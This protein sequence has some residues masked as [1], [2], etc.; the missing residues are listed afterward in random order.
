MEVHA[1]DDKSPQL[2]QVLE[3]HRRFRATLGFLPT[4]AFEERAAVGTLLLAVDGAGRAIGYALYDLPRAEIALRHLCVDEPAR[5]KGAAKALVEAIAERHPERRGIRVRCR[6]DWPANGMWP[7]LDF[8][9]VSDAPGRSVAGHLLTTWWRDFG[10]PTLFTAQESVGP[11]VRLAIDTDVFIDLSTDRPGCDESRG[12]LSDWVVE[13][14]EIVV[15]KEVTQ[16]LN[17]HS[18]PATRDQH[19]ARLQGFQRADASPAEWARSVDAL[20]SALPNAS[21][22]S[23]HDEADIRHVARAHAA[24]VRYFVTRDEGLIVR[25]AEPAAMALGMVVVSPGAFL[26]LLWDQGADTYAPARIENTPIAVDAL[27]GNDIDLVAR[28]FLNH[29]SG[30]RLPAFRQA[31]RRLLADPQRYETR[32]VRV[33][34]GDVLGVFSRFR[35]GD[36]LEVPLL[37]TAGRLSGTIGR[38]IVYLQRLHAR[39]AGTPLVRVSEKELSASVVDALQAE[40]FVA[41]TS[42]WW[43][44]VVSTAGSARDIA[45]ELLTVDG[46]PELGLAH[47]AEALRGLAAPATVIEIESRF[48]PL[49]VRNA[50]VPTY[51]V[52]IRAPFAQQLFD[53]DLST[54]TLFARS[55]SLGL[56]REHVYYRARRPNVMQAP[57]RIV[58]YVSQDPHLP[59][60]GAIRA[61]SRLVEI[62]IE[63]PRTLYRRFGHLGVYRL[64]DV[65]Q[66]AGSSGVAMAVRFTDTETLRPVSLSVLREI[67]AR[68]GRN[69]SLRSPWKLPEGMFDEIY[70]RGMHE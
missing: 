4:T 41:T 49:K 40:S 55:E 37:R 62:V 67:G 15:T 69:P 44:S 35:S 11:L 65:Q 28:T 51:L 39:S 66:A 22:R 14:A 50:Q 56:S 19:R 26:Q 17:H 57:A 1:I 64:S 63:R 34:A 59:G 70:E 31:L 52:P 29:G 27:S 13:R 36:V 23:E 45:Q 21:S 5:G 12:L 48:W 30:E 2:R 47:A 53:T 42:G 68:Y 43:S 20:T 60:T 6:R 61:C 24:G 3:L 58:W 38:Q 9:P 7:R 32:V 54:R 18:D 16:E 25:L 46:P 33:A 8:E 10:H